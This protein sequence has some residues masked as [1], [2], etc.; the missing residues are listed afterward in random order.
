MLTEQTTKGKQENKKRHQQ[1]LVFFL[2]AIQE[3]C[4][5]K[6]IYPPLFLASQKILCEAGSQII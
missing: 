3:T 5:K 2:S 4:A 6:T 1:N